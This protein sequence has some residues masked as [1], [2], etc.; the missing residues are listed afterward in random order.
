[1][2]SKCG[3]V[4]PISEWDGCTGTHWSEVGELIHRAA[5]G[6]GY[7]SELVSEADDVGVIHKRIVQNLYECPVVVVDI[8]GRNANVMF[9]LGMRLA[10][11]KP[12]VII[13]DDKTPFSFDTSPLEH[14][15]YPRDLRY[16]KVEPFVK[17]LSEKIS[18]SV[19]GEGRDSFLKSFGSFKVAEITVEKAPLD[20]LILE[21]MGVLKSEI[22][23]I[24]TSF[25]RGVMPNSPRS[26][27]DAMFGKEISKS[28]NS[29]RMTFPLEGLPTTIGSR[30]ISEELKAL[31]DRV[32]N[33]EGVKE[34]YIE[35]SEDESILTVLLDAQMPT[36]QVSRK[37][38]MVKRWMASFSSQDVE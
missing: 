1:M 32:S 21:E 38:E 26:I 11:D 2:N 33:I 15:T 5:I 29:R 25:L 24:R 18:K 37:Y 8:S 9:E 7:E 16:S 35:S 30:N 13:K 28:V 6:A 3:V 36:S 20:E 22:R 14:L 34:V 12:T 17:H 4:R 23:Q 31:M 27:R 10:F 19:E